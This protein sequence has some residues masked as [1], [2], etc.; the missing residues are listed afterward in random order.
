MSQQ[1]RV[2]SEFAPA[3]KLVIEEEFV[4]DALFDT[5][6]LFHD[7]RTRAAFHLMAAIERGVIAAM[8]PAIVRHGLTLADPE[9]LRA[10]GRRE[11]EVMRSTSWLSF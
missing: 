8:Q 1:P 10:D 5:L 3:L 11:A 7:G 6:A 2:F 9:S 4:G